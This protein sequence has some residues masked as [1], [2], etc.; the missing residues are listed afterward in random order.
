VFQRSGSE[1]IG[2]ESDSILLEDLAKEDNAEM[3]TMGLIAR[4]KSPNRIAARYHDE[5]VEGAISG[6]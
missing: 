6:A 1:R 3:I 5:F 4:K 2:Q